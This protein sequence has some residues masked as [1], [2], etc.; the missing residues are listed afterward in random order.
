[1]EDKG[2]LGAFEHTHTNEVAGHQVSRE[3][4]T[5]EVQPQ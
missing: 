3:L 5:A 2:I 1:M 4:D